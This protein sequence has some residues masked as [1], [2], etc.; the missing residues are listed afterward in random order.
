VVSGLESSGPSQ[1]RLVSMLLHCH[2]VEERR[3]IVRKDNSRF[4]KTYC[5]TCVRMGTVEKDASMHGSLEKFILS[6]WLPRWSLR[7]SILSS[8]DTN[9]R[10][11]MSASPSKRQWHLAAKFPRRRSE[12][13]CLQLSSCRHHAG[14]V[15]PI[16]QEDLTQILRNFS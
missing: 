8:F 7:R 4:L 11:R 16:S 10:C 2:V 3:T 5:T 1:P 13:M 6:S 14:T 9:P 15:R 12:R